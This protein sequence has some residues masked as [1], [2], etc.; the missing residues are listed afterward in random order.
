MKRNPPRLVFWETTSR[1]NLQCVHCRRTNVPE[2]GDELYELPTAE[3]KAILLSLKGEGRPPM[4]VFSGGEPLMRKDLPELLAYAKDNGIPFAIATN[5]ALVDEAMTKMLASYGPHRI[6]VSLDGAVA[7]TH[8]DFRGQKGS[9]DKAV[10]ALKLF[11]A[12][13]ISTQINCSVS[14]R[15][16]AER[17][18]VVKLARE[19]GVDALHF[20]LLVPVGCGAELPD[21]MRLGAENYE[22]FL[23][24]LMVR[25]GAAGHPAHGH[26]HGHG[27]PAPGGME[28]RATCAPH[29]TRIVRQKVA[30][31]SPEFSGKVAQMRGCLAGSAIAFISHKGEVFPCGYL[32][33][34]AGDLRK[35]NFWEVWENSEV[36]KTIS[37]P[38]ALK[39]K[40]GVCEFR[41][42]CAGCRARAFGTTGDY[43][44]Q[45]PY[46]LYEPKAKAK[47]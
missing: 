36:F 22:E 37:D 21:A 41:V 20:F 16:V 6:S 1:C 28:I 14:T 39:G 19:L 11:R 45:E 5:G 27:H 40:C 31:S 25:Q 10:N 26:G 12:A 4:V 32:P 44:G 29:Q 7:A 3:F 18:A 30:A 33:V 35:Q 24:W 17:D 15:N 34:P 13:G 23:N 43:M 46:C 8:D 42:I 38:D 9:F 47:S 2:R